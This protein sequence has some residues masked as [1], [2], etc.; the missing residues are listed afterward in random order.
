MP[1][2]DFVVFIRFSNGDKNF[3]LILSFFTLHD[4]LLFEILSLKHA[5]ACSLIWQSEKY[6]GFMKLM[7]E[8]APKRIRLNKYINYT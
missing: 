8:L 5:V 3:Y 6:L 7:S 4:V 2:L 1:A